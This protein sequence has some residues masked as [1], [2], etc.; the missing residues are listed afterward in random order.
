MIYIGNH[1]S[2]SKGYAAMGSHALSLGGDTFGVCLPAE[3]FNQERAE[4]KLSDF[5]VND[6]TT[7]HHLLIHIGVYRVAERDIPVSVMYDRAHMALDTV[8]EEYHVITGWYEDSLRDQV[9]WNQQI[10]AELPEAMT[11]TERP[12]G[13][14]RWSVGS[15]RRTGSGIPDRS[16]PCLNRTA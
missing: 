16:F 4:Q 6:G 7:E 15:T 1:V 12:S 8:K 5:V 11:G 13:Q 10:S 2:V 9:L 14:K 3:E